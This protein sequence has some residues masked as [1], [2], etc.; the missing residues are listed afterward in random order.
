MSL[1][2]RQCFRVFGGGKTENNTCIRHNST[3][4]K[5]H[6]SDRTCESN[7]RT[8]CDGSPGSHRL[9]RTRPA[10]ASQPRETPAQKPW[11]YAAIEQG[12]KRTSGRHAGISV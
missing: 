11:V 9:H 5:V 8:L 1:E 12:L 7:A 4:D 3:H 2:V 6:S 10:P